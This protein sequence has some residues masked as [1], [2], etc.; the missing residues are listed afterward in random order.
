MPKKEQTHSKEKV[1]RD[2][3]LRAI[4]RIALAEDCDPFAILGPHWIERDSRPLLAIRAFR[5]GGLIAPDKIARDA[6]CRV[7]HGASAKSLLT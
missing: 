6:L 7:F 5:P 3:F 4:E 2:P 1:I